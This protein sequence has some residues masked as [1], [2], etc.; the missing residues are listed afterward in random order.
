MRVRRIPRRLDPVR[1]RQ[2]RVQ[3]RRGGGLH[4]VDDLLEQRGIVATHDVVLEGGA[5]ARVEQHEIDPIAALQVRRELVQAPLRVRHAIFGRHRAGPVEEHG[6]VEGLPR[7]VG[8]PDGQRDRQLIAVRLGAPQHAERAPAR[9]LDGVEAEVVEQLVGAD[10]PRRQR[11][12]PRQG[13]QHPLGR[14]EAHRVVVRQVHRAAPLVHGLRLALA[15]LLLRRR[16]GVDRPLVGRLLPIPTEHD[17]LRGRIGRILG[18]FG[19][20]V[21]GLGVEPLRLGLRDRTLRGLRF[22][23]LLLRARAA[24]A[25]GLVPRAVADLSAATNH[26]PDDTAAEITGGSAASSPALARA[27]GAESA[28]RGHGR[29]GGGRGGGGRL[30]RGRGCGRSGLGGRAPAGRGLGGLAVAAGR[31]EPAEAVADDGLTRRQGGVD[32]LGAL[33][34][35]LG[36]RSGDVQPG[37]RRWVGRHRSLDLFRLSAA[38]ER[39]RNQHP[40]LPNVVVPGRTHGR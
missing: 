39:D 31:S 18:R 10:L 38:N 27:D 37:R 33:G 2:T 8:A 30:L 26:A 9:R 40:N 28:S 21:V 23:A 3:I 12:A 14:G 6:Q 7:G 1:F 4:R 24:P 15:L 16:V 5:H 36:G 11:H 19:G 29:L 22:L 13:V 25:V 35:P 17:R 32:D 20:R 34:D